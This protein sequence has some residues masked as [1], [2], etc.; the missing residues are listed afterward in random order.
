MSSIH[1][2][3]GKM[4]RIQV[5]LYPNHLLGVEGAYIARNESET[6]LSIEDVCEHM[7]DHTSS[8]SYKDTAEIIRRFLDEAMYQLCSGKAVNLDYYSI[9]PYVG[10]TFNTAHKAHDH[11]KNPVTFRFRTRKAMR[12]LTKNTDV[13]ITAVADSKSYIEEFTA[14]YSEAV[15]E[16]VMPGEQFIISGHKIKVEGDDPSC[17][18]YFASVTDNILDGRRIK[19]YDLAENSSPRIIGVVPL[20]EVPN[21][22][23]VVIISQ[24]TGSGTFLKEPHVITSRF[25]LEAA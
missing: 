9:H 22:Y 7:K 4:N 11:K 25:T 5:K 13:V 17:G 3:N 21:K 19:V 18:V 16:T 15:N 14:V 23:K 1:D 6:P 8:G 20:L 2:E 12:D 10:G 24:H